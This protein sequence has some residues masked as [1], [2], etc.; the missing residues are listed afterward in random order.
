M[1]IAGHDAGSS[2]EVGPTNQRVID[3]A[4]AKLSLS[5]DHGGC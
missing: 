4:R 1:Q 3:E 5:R 2:V